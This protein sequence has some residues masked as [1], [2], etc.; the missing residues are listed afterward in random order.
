MLD[1]MDGTGVI[2]VAALHRRY[3]RGGRGFEAVRGVSVTIRRGELFALL[4]TNGAGKT[5][6]FEVVAG[7]MPATSGSVR[8]LG[9]DPRAE[10][11]AVRPHM[12]VVWQDSGFP[13][14][15]TVTETA[16][17]WAGTLTAPR[18]VGEALDLV[19][20]GHRARV[21]VRQ[22]SGG[23][24]RRLDLALALL[25]RPQVLLLDE[26]TAGLDPESRH[27]VWQLLREL[28]DGGSTVLLTTHHL[29]EAESLADRLA[30]MHRGRIV[31]LGTRAEVVGQQPARI[32]FGWPPGAP[33]ALPALPGSVTVERTPG[34]VLVRTADLQLT[35]T[36]LLD[37]ANR[38]DLRLPQFTAGPASLQET[39]LALA[40][41]GAQPHDHE[42]AA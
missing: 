18:P 42:R 1:H 41:S 21:A 32:T 30:I 6:L 11:R 37:W 15:L 2:D 17:M 23:E 3:G 9:R 19:N 25:G 34:G 12:G 16:R 28:L 7:L 36:A 29:D 4:G 31:R 5:S 20:L 40:E 27:G 14:D 10:R 8:V 35:V 33:P 24:R 22:L 13:P 38:H 26:P 39:F